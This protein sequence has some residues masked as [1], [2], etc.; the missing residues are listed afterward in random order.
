MIQNITKHYLI[1]GLIASLIGSIC[2]VK[3]TEET[4][5]IPYKKSD[6]TIPKEYSK[7]INDYPKNWHRLSG[8]EYSALHWEQFVV[9]YIN[10]KTDTYLNNHYEFMRIYEEDLDPEEDEINYKKYVVGTIILKESF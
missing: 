8:Y 5:K 9:V 2:I 7:I 3:A 10:N 6:F 1:A 4:K